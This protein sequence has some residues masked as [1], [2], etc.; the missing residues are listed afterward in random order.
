MDYRRRKLAK[1]GTRLYNQVKP[2]GK[3]DGL[4]YQKYPINSKQ[5]SFI[6][7][8]AWFNDRKGR[9]S[10]G[11]QSRGNIRF[12]LSLLNRPQHYSRAATSMLNSLGG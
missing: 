11:W 12:S 6:P 4:Q 9:D 1:S 2:I 3:T 5:R 7:K 8:T 10:N